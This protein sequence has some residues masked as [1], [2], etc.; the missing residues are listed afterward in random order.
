M[1]S[2]A[3]QTIFIPDKYLTLERK[4]TVKSEY[5]NGEILAMSGASLAHTR[6][7]LDLGWI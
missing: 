5:L 7:T 4:A 2:P 1:S 3:A 6:I